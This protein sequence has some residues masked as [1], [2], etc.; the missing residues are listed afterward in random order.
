M[1]IFE[2]A[3]KEYLEIAKDEKYIFLTEFDQDHGILKKKNSVDLEIKW[4]DWAH[5]LPGFNRFDFSHLAPNEITMP[6]LGIQLHWLMSHEGY[7][8]NPEILTLINDSVLSGID[9]LLII[10]SHPN[11]FHGDASTHNFL[12][13]NSKPYWIDPLFPENGYPSE[14]DIQSFFVSVAINWDEYPTKFLE[15]LPQIKKNMLTH[16]NLKLGEM[17]LP[18]R[19]QMSKDK[20]ELVKCF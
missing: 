3:Y 15:Y 8:T 16:T 11:M 6:Y 7:C 14:S 2:Q 17:G 10:A 1:S 20:E 4:Y 18:Y 9:Q 19:Y 5:T 13:G 12:I